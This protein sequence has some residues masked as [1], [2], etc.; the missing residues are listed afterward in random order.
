MLLKKVSRF[1][2]FYGW[3]CFFRIALNVFLPNRAC[4]KVVVPKINYSD[5]YYFKRL[6]ASRVVFFPPEKK[7]S[8]VVINKKK[9]WTLWLQGEDYAPDIVKACWMSLRRHLPSD[10]ELVVLD[11]Q[12]IKEYVHLPDFIEL[13]YSSGV[14][15]MAHYSDLIRLKLL[16]DYGG[17]WVDSTVYCSN[18][19]LFNFLQESKPPL[20]VYKNILR[21]DDACALSNWFIYAEPDNPILKNVYIF[22]IE[23]WKQHNKPR[24]YFLFH[25]IFKVVIE[26]LANEWGKVPTVSNVEPH[27]LATR[28]FDDFDEKYFNYIGNTSSFHKLSYKNNES[29]IMK[30]GTYYKYIISR[31]LGG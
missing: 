28:L 6:F 16:L 24:N 20:F 10:F 14:I 29:D 15:K 4:L 11:Q 27:I 9:V 30:T 26:K 12:K 21:H 19:M 13:K 23:Y 7:E 17:C 2:S 1:I 18:N 8:T 25:I 5:Y 31:E 3:K 22:L